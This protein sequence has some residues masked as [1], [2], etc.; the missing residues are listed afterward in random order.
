MFEWVKL[1]FQKAIAY[2][3]GKLINVP[4]QTWQ[5]LEAQEHEWAFAVAGATKAELLADLRRSVEQ[6]LTEGKSLGQFK[7]EFREIAQRHGWQHKGDA[8]WR[9]RVIY[10]ANL[11]MAYQGGRREQ[12][13]QVTDTFPY[14]MWVHGDSRSPRS[15]HLALDG[16]VFRADDPFWRNHYPPIFAGA[17]AWGCKCRTRMLSRGQLERL[18][19]QVE[20]PPQSDE[21]LDVTLPDGRR[22]AARMPRKTGEDYVPGLGRQEQR[23]RVLQGILD[24]LPPELR[25][26]LEDEIRNR[27]TPEALLRE[28][29]RLGVKHTPGNIVRIG[30]Q[31]NGRVV[32]LEQGNTGGD[33][34]GLAH[35]IERHLDQF[36]DQDV[37][38]TDIP[39][40]IVQAATQGRLALRQGTRDVFEVVFRGQTRY[41][42][43]TISD[44]GYVVGAN[45]IGRRTFAKLQRQQERRNVQT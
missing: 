8:D 28:L 7:K 13:E 11:R 37:Q 20:I 33:G 3:L 5:D 10:Q 12:Q 29:Q 22:V 45:P 27:N 43:L 39:D 30:R 1:S 32:F 41:V 18:G 26:Q 34:R 6:A 38:E 15:H 21:L 14:R 17:M 16:K 24:R 35:I 9:A 44:N 42:A 4:T 25:G 19:K 36:L 31:P 40:L 23:R 2:F